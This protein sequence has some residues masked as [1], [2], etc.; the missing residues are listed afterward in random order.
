MTLRRQFGRKLLVSLIG[1]WQGSHVT[2][3]GNPVVLSLLKRE[4]V[5]SLQSQASVGASEGCWVLSWPRAELL[6]WLHLALSCL[7][8]ILSLCFSGCGLRLV[9]AH[10]LLTISLQRHKDRKLRVF[11]NF[12]SVESNNF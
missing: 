6:F 5:V 2:P 8:C 9:P 10:K 4:E 11:Q 12:M 3:A 1:D 7:A